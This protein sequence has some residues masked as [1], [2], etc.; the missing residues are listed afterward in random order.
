[1][2]RTGA[3]SLDGAPVCVFFV[4]V[5]RRG[6]DYTKDSTSLTDKHGKSICANG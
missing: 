1:M 6:E 3:P 2:E 5:L 4:V